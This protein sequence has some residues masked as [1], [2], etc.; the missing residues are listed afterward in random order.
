MSIRDNID[1]LIWDFKYGSAKDKLKASAKLASLGF[2]VATLFTGAGAA[3]KT[4][5]TA[6]KLSKCGKGAKMVV[7]F[8][9]NA[10]GKNLAKA[11]S[12]IIKQQFAKN[13]IN[14][15]NK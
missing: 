11:G 8:T 2:D 4:V 12:K 3:F 6:S 1:D 10:Q 5:K 13:T 7:T 14:K 15:F 9:A